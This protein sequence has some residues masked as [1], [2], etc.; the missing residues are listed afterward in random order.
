MLKT[1]MEKLFERNVNQDEDIVFT[2]EPYIMYEQFQLDDNFK[3]YLV[4]IMQSK[5]VYKRGIKPTPYQ[6]LFELANSTES[7]IVDFT[8]VN[9][10]ILFF[11]YLIMLS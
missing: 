9:K 1:A 7:C 3:I 10:G 5:H 2:G 11:R 4:G 8:V 6:K